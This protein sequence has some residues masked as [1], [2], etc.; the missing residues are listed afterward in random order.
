MR[1]LI[2]LLLL[3]STVLAWQSSDVTFETVSMTYPQ[4]KKV[5]VPMLGTERFAK[6]IRGEAV[7]ERRKSVTFITLDIGRLAPPSQLGPAA[8]T[9]VIWAITPEGMADNLGEFRL[10][11]SET[12]DNWFGSEIATSTPH[13][14]FSLIITAEPHY[15][16]SSPSRLVVVANQGVREAGV[17]GSINRISFSGDSDYERVL[18]APDPTATRKDP[19]YPVELLMAHNALEIARYYEAETYAQELYKKAQ[20]RLEQAEAEYKANNASGAREIAD[21]SIRLAVQ[22]RALAAGRRRA[23]AQRELLNEKDEYLAELEDKIRTSSEQMRALQERADEAVRLRTQVEQENRQLLAET[24]RL[25][26]ELNLAQRELELERARIGTGQADLERLQ[27]ENARLRAELSRLTETSAQLER[28]RRVSALKEQVMKS[29]ETRNDPR[30]VVVVVPDGVFAGEASAVISTDGSYRLK[31]LAELLAATA[32][33]VYIEGYSDNRGTQEARFRLSRGRA[34]ALLNYFSSH[35]VATERMQAFA[36]G[37]SKPVA[38]NTSQQGRAAN[39]RV[40]VVL[41]T[42]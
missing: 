41:A 36:N 3:P 18:V 17:S 8:A 39:R 1:L 25:Q 24:T 14:T 22:T 19:K 9:Y 6:N 29:F 32:S 31:P 12:L 7:I 13:R 30:G 37:S 20:E 34:E 27:E 42:P 2:L 16:V 21:I 23:R 33:P 10:R 26:R 38:A 15:L 28:E 5:R 11:D 35:G 40:E 4:G